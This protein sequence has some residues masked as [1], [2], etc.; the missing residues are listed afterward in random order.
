MRVARLISRRN[1]CPRAVTGAVLVLDGRIVSTGYVGAPAGMPHCTAV[2]CEGVDR[3]NG[4]GCTRTVHAELNA[5]VFA[6]RKGIATEGAVLYTWQAPCLGCAKAVL[7]AGIV[8]V[9][10]A[11][12][13]RDPAGLEL[14][15]RAGTRLDRYPAVLDDKRLIDR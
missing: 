9:V 14:L 3:Q 7:N 4:E 12:S 10:Y 13:Y 2:G 1:T 8:R 6:A 15:A 5:I 11:V